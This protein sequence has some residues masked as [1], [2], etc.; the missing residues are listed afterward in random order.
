MLAPQGLPLSLQR[1]RE[2]EEGVVADLDGPQGRK[3]GN[4]V[5][6]IPLP[7]GITR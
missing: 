1:L 6:I 7:D 2:A 3:L 4:L 5:A